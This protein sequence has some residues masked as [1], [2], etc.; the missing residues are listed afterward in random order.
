MMTEMRATTDSWPGQRFRF[1][2]KILRYKMHYKN[3]GEILHRDAFPINYFCRAIAIR[4]KRASTA[5]HRNRQLFGFSALKMEINK[6]ENG[7]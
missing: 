2:M 4:V 7:K 6:T 3:L 1:A 5:K